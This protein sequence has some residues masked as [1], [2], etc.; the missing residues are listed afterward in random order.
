MKRYFNVVSADSHK[1]CNERFN[2]V[3][4]RLSPK[5]LPSN[6][7]IIET[8]A[9]PAVA[10]FNNGAASI[11]KVMATKGV[12]IGTR[13]TEFTSSR[14]SRYYN[15]AELR[16]QHATRESRIQRRLVKNK[17]NEEEKAQEV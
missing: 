4:W 13:A 11:L 16:V 6:T 8:A 7:T 3:L 12:K 2:S 5:H 10:Y 1:N 17:R 14:V 9:Y 15:Q